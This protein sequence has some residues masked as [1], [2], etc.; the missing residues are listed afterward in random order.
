M[1]V[2]RKKNLDSIPEHAVQVNIL[3]PACEFRNLK[4][5][6]YEKNLQKYGVWTRLSPTIS[7]RRSRDGSML[8]RAGWNMPY[9]LF[10]KGG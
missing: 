7:G 3:S 6:V 8:P 4:M 10:E 2:I 9:R 5:Q 1:P